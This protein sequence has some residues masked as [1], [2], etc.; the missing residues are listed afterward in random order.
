MEFLV[1]SACDYAEYILN[2]AFHFSIS[3]VAFSYCDGKWDMQKEA[4]QH[5]FLPFAFCLPL[6]RNSS[7][8]QEL[9]KFKP[10]LKC[11]LVSSESDESLENRFQGMWLDSIS[12]YQC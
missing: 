12:W 11:H 6:H 5:Y 7:F 4:Q 9:E 8:N 3:A 10:E 2:T 1:W